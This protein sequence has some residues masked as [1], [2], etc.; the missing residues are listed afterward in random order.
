MRISGTEPASVILSQTMLFKKL[1]S[2]AQNYLN[3]LN[4]KG[5]V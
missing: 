2:D 4:P 1:T 5:M 3:K